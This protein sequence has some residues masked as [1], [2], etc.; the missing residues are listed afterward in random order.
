MPHKHGRERV[1]RAALELF[2]QR[3][4][5]AT[6]TRDIARRAGLAEGTLYRH[7]RT[8]RELAVSLF[9]TLA[10]RLRDALQNRLRGVHDPEEQ[11]RAFVHGFFDFAAQE[12][13]AYEFIV[14]RHPDLRRLPPAVPLPKDLLV[15]ILRRGVRRRKFRAIDPALATAMIVGMT[16]RVI[17]FLSQSAIRRPRR[18]VADAVA[19]AALR[20]VRAI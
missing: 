6:T 14:H 9:L 15:Q 17:L 12:P 2:A 5:D 18:E 19:D 20:I 11:I 3:G 4:V 16:V 10:G 1:T 7:F 13:A 8:K